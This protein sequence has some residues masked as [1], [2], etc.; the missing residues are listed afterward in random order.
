MKTIYLVR[1]AESKA[2]S[3]EDPDEVNP[4][5][6]LKGEE[7]AKALGEQLRT[8]AVNKVYLS[9]LL[10]AWMTFRL[11][12]I[13]PRTTYV[14]SLLAEEHSGNPGIYRELISSPDPAIFPGDEDDAWELD[15]IER[16]RRLLI[17]L[18]RD[19]ASTIVCFG[20]WAIFNRLL[21]VFLGYEAELTERRLV[22]ENCSISKL[23]V[24]PDGARL[25]EYLNSPTLR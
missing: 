24:E 4:L 22:F 7:Q 3:G 17:K 1:H 15:G 20:H 16:S 2:Q 5:L 6:S 21:Q 25:V 13:K 19:K 18:V 8:M 9:P 12:D 23:L 11:A 14:T 10:R